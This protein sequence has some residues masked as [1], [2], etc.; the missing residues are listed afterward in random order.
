MSAAVEQSI[1]VLRARGVVDPVE[2][3]VLLGFGLGGMA[4]GLAD[5]VAIP[6]A[7]LPALPALDE[8]G[9]NGRLIVGRLEGV[10]VCCLQGQAHFYNS[11]DPA[12]MNDALELVK[13]LGARQLLIFGAAGSVRQD[14]YP[15]NLALV[16]DHIAFSGLNPLI[17][18]IDPRAFVSLNEAYDPRLQ[19]RLKRAAAVA[20]VAA[21]EGVFMWLSGPTFATPAESK[22][23]RALGADLAGFGVAPEIILAR[24]LG[25]RAAAM[26]VITHFSAG[27]QASDPNVVECQQQAL[28]GSIGLRRILR[29][30]L[31]TADALA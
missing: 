29:A 22:M 21:H 5:A 24:R 23:A 10:N 9:Q 17:G 2:V 12:C 8:P 14:L 26:A 4:E 3:A 19:R 1:Q 28:A 6:Y 31:K 20:G 7:D 25:L 16:T 15:G 13:A 27:V 11:G 18:L 30:Y